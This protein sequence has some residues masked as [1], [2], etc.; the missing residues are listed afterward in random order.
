MF[1]LKPDFEQ[2][3]D[4]F[5]AWWECDILDRPIAMISF[6]KPASEQTPLPRKEHAT[7]R[8]RW[9]DVEYAVEKAVVGLSNGVAYAEML[10]VAYPNLGPEVFSAYYGC[11]MKY[12]EST[13]WSV[14]ILEDMSEDSTAKLQFREDN[15]YFQK[16]LELTDALLEAA[17]GK[18]IVGYTDLHP[19]GDAIAAFR[20][21]QNLCMD[22][23]THPAEAKA[24]AMRMSEEFCTI[25]D[26]FH[27]KLQAAGMPSTTWLRATCRG[28]YHVPSNDF[29]CM[30]SPKMF[31][32]AF[33]P[34]IALE[35][36]HMDRNI[37][38]LDGPDALP[39]LDA[40]MDVPGMDAIQ[41]V[42]GV[43]NGP[44]LKWLDVYKRIQA[45]GK[46]LQVFLD[47]SEVDR[48]TQE[49]K[50]EGVLACVSGVENQAQ[51]D[52]VLKTLS[53]WKS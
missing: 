10:P 39:H 15:F 49:L 47:A 41:W 27:D 38:H 43:N 5:E 16:T 21:P 42:Y 50:P 11:D 6:P 44:W 20:D 13:A 40:L 53:R 4:R 46:A 48:M 31:E 34:G 33:L 23:V 26:I 9:M 17:K 24:L 30:I 36:A 28:K 14:P 52:D 8:D 12:G 35:C 1:E 25:Y 7:L 29:S 22:M 3:M 2:V 45:R 18:F 19:G 51:A 32:E 37:Y